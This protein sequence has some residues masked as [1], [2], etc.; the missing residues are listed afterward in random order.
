MIKAA[1]RPRVALLMLVDKSF[2]R[3]CDK[4]VTVAKTVLFYVAI[5]LVDEMCEHGAYLGIWVTLL[6]HEP[7]VSLRL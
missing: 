5:H 6:S 3:L 2:S 7:F 1:S 4:P